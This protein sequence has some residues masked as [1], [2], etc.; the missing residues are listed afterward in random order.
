MKTVILDTNILFSA[1]RANNSKIRTIL[2][3]EDYTFY[4]PNF[5]VV[6]IFKHKEKIL[7]K[8]TATPDDVYEFLGKMMKKLNFVN[9]DFISLGNLV[10]AHKLCYEIDEADTLF[11]ALALELNGE[12]WTGD[13]KLKRHLEQKGFLQFFDFSNQP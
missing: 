2:S 5:L 8:S 9:E 11:V 4:T 13:E 10:Y 6:E 1:L 7:Q 12:L 3:R